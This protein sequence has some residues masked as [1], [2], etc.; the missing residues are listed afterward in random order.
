MHTT[1]RGVNSRLVQICVEGGWHFMINAEGYC[2]FS[3][4]CWLSWV[5]HF[6]DVRCIAIIPKRSEANRFRL[7]ALSEDRCLYNLTMFFDWFF[8]LRR[9]KI[10]SAGYLR[11]EALPLE[12]VFLSARSDFRRID[13]RTDEC[14][15]WVDVSTLLV[16]VQRDQWWRCSQY[17]TRRLWRYGAKTRMI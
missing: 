15:R 14:S 10:W 5:W 12:C 7:F 11:L 8:F 3:R 17:H 2:T 6:V 1:V 4:R 9:R 13:H 16:R